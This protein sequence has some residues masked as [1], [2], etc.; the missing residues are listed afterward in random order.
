MKR[1]QPFVILAPGAYVVTLQ[2]RAVEGLSGLFTRV[3]RAQVEL[4]VLRG[5]NYAEGLYG[6]RRSLNEVENVATIGR[7]DLIRVDLVQE[8]RGHKATAGAADVKETRII[9]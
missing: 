2:C 4:R 3:D 6:N 1:T 8:A 7:K 9:C 5:A